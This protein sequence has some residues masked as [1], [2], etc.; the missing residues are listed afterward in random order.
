MIQTSQFSF[1]RKFTSHKMFEKDKTMIDSKLV[2]RL[3]IQKRAV[4]NANG[5]QHIILNDK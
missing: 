4:E 5:G 1:S 3:V 2:G